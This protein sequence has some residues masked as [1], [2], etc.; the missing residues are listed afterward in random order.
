VIIGNLAQLAS[1]P[2]GM[3]LGSNFVLA[4]TVLFLTKAS[5]TFLAMV[6]IPEVAV[7]R[8]DVART[9]SRI[10]YRNS[11]VGYRV[12]VEVSRETVLGVFRI[13]ALSLILTTLYLIYRTLLLLIT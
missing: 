9:Y 2:I 8:E 13:L 1:A 12:A 7:L 10:L 3:F 6:F 5:A 11:I 4:F